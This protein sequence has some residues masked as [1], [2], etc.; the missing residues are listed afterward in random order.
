MIQTALPTVNMP[1]RALSLP[2]ILLRAES[3]AVLIGALA[4]YA[5]QGGSWGTFILLLL[6]PDLSALGYLVNPR[7]GALG[8]NIGHFYV[9]PALLLALSWNAGWSAGI[10]LALIWFAHIGMDRVIGYGLKYAI[11]FKSTHLQ[12]V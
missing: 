5:H 3:A 10:Q 4:L 2:N 12:R 7:I 9:L 6:V 1:T 8:Y 11:E